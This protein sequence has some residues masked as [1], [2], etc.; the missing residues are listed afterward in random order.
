ME[1]DRGSLVTALGE[2]QKRKR[3]ALD[4]ASPETKACNAQATSKL[5]E[6]EET[7]PSA[8][9]LKDDGLGSRVADS[10]LVS[11]QVAPLG[12]HW[13]RLGTGA[14]SCCTLRA[15]GRS[16]PPAPTTRQRLVLALGP[17]MT[18]RGRSLHLLLKW[19]RAP[20]CF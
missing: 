10:P 4:E 20:R 8:K 9:L 1:V 6:P 12:A 11:G 19:T 15:P 18:S 5:G 14:C 7:S 16:L 3:D 13:P 2:A 17:Q